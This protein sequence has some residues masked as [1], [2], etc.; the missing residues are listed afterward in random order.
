MRRV[1]LL[2]LAVIAL[3]QTASS[4]AQ[5]FD[6]QAVMAACRTD[7]M[8]Y[9]PGVAP[10]GG[11]I[12]QCLASYQDR[13]S[14]V[15]REAVTVGATCVADIQRYCANASPQGNAIISCLKSITPE[16]APDCARAISTYASR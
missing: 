11:R 13:I 1:F 7:Y 10:G 9:C 6:R 4:H 15:C 5:G 3:A 8:T 12:L 2:S 14:P 16:L